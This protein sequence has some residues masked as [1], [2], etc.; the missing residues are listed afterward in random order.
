MLIMLLE[1]FNPVLKDYIWN[2]DMDFNV[3]NVYNQFVNITY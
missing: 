1:Q 2:L 3:C